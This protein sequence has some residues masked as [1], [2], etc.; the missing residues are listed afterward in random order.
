MSMRDHFRPPLS[1]RT[2]WEAVPGGWPM[3]I[4]QTL[5]DTLPETFVAE[6]R[7]HLGTQIEIDVASFDQQAVGDTVGIAEEAEPT[8]TLWTPAEP[9]LVLE[10][11]MADFDEYEVR[12]FDTRRGRRL[13]AAI[14]IVSPA[15]KDRP[16]SRSQF[17][18]KCAALLRQGVSL[19]IVDL[20]TI[21]EANLYADLLDLI[22]RR[23]PDLGETPP[24][25][26]AAACRWRP[27]DTRHYFEVWNRRLE[28]A[29]PL[30]CL[31]L[32]LTDDLAIPLDLEASY[33][34]TCHNLRIG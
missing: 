7:V 1:D 25:T 11:E 16:E 33:E 29:E 32:W 22:E 4:V 19:V 5:G 21:R 10:T 3:V 2:T 26:Y 28:V 24:R 18:A 31:P 20:V 17:V 23:D 12:V 14:E 13:V 27:R 34:R 15:N 8:P 6:P 30:P 9:T